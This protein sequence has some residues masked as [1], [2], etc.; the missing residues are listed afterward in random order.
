MLRRGA[1]RTIAVSKSLNPSLPSASTQPSKQLTLTW[2]N[3]Q[4]MAEINLYLQ[5]CP[6]SA[7]DTDLLQAKIQ[8]TPSSLNGNTP[9]TTI[10]HHI[11]SYS[12]WFY[13]TLLRSGN[14]LAKTSDMKPRVPDRKFLTHEHFTDPLTID[15][16][17]TRN[18][19]LHLTE[20]KIDM[21]LPEHRSIL[22]DSKMIF[23]SGAPAIGKSIRVCRQVVL[24]GS[25]LILSANRS[26]NTFTTITL[27]NNGRFAFFIAARTISAPTLSHRSWPPSTNPSIV[28]PSIRCEDQSP[29]EWSF[30]FAHPRSCHAEANSLISITT[31]EFLLH[32]LIG[33]DYLLKSSLTHLI[34]DDAH[35]RS[36]TLDMLLAFLKDSQHKYRHL[37]IILLQSTIQYDT[38]VK[39]FSSAVTY[40]SKAK[41]G[42]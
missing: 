4:I 19:L 27:T 42:E 26:V 22:V 29:S 33:G 24:L 14:P 21:V 30:S 16:T 2:N 37:K 18:D 36:H 9:P 41:R 5:S 7:A 28:S 31:H 25:P 3:P 1:S 40:N 20:S 15:H 34:I 10:T 35:K 13:C 6:I 17:S 23:L 39:Y 38:L 8:K 11:L 12:D 32:T